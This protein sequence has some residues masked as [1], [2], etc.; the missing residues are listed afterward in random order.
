ML[1]FVKITLMKILIGSA[2]AGGGHNSIAKVLQSAL[3][4]LNPLLDNEIYHVQGKKAGIYYRL[5]G[6]KTF[7]HFYHR[8]NNLIGREIALLLIEQIVIREIKKMIN[9]KHPDLVLAVYPFYGQTL[10]K[11][12]VPYVTFVTD[13]FLFHSVWADTESKYLVV[14]SQ[15]AKKR[16]QKFLVPDKKIIFYPFPLKNE[17]FIKKD[18]NNLKNQY[19]IK[20]NEFVLTIGG[21]GDGMERSQIICK[22]LHQTNLPFKAFVICGKNLLLRTKLKTRLYLDKRFEIIGFTDKIDE[23]LRISDLFVGKVGANILFEC[24][25]L[26]LPILT[27]IPFFGQEDGN[28]E[29][30]LKEKIG[31]VEK[32]PKS[33]V[34]L[35]IQLIQN[36]AFLKRKRHKMTKIK[37]QYVT[38]S[39]NIK[40]LLKKLIN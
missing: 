8:T 16:A 1:I 6:V 9:K 33:V 18:L 2:H 31:W 10:A 24:L 20:K 34:R 40:P 11:L 38:S 27:T 29:F 23:Y 35:I 14:F 21:S 5:F 28:R 22:Y 37:D 26:T 12:K 32:E 13:P 25:Q 17:F 4:D 39:D 36:P 15:E 7:N 30:I 3:N 19:K